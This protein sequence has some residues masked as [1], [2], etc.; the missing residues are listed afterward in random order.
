MRIF[1]LLAFGIVVMAVATVVI[2]S[3]AG[4]PTI[5][6]KA[7][8]LIGAHSFDAEIADTLTTRNKGLS[9]R[10]SLPPNSAMLFVFGI[11]GAYGF[12]MKDMRFPIDIVWMRKGKIIG[13]AENVQPEP[14]KNILRLQS[15]YPPSA[16]DRVL[17]INAGL[18]KQHGFTVGDAVR[19]V[20]GA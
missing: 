1:S 10:P 11:P 13:F 12:W 18:V 15:Y 20:F 4:A 8:V 7:A 16:V 2:R 5:P 19:I 3:S 17:E 14:G 9:G 6:Q